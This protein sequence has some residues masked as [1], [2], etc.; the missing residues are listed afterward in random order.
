MAKDP[1]ARALDR[2][3]A[4][5]PAR[6]L[7]ERSFT[8]RGRNFHRQTG[9]LVRSVWFQT[10]RGGP[11]IFCINLTVLSP[12]LHEMVHG[13][14]L[15]SSPSLLNSVPL[16]SRRV[17]WPTEDGPN[18]WFMWLPANAEAGL[19]AE[20]E[21][22]RADPARVGQ[23]LEAD[24]PWFDRWPTVDSILERYEAGPPF[25]DGSGI[26]PTQVEHAVL[27]A[28]RG[29][30]DRALELLREGAARAGDPGAH[31]EIASRLRQSPGQDQTTRL[32]F[33]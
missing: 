19:V 15:P 2:L 17:S 20:R 18:N 14:P 5:E 1:A 8:K 11:G 10:M 28:Y 7:R 29:H 12:F 13:E 16:A 31:A 25:E 23:C 24:L 26:G 6:L 21:R 30:L 4:E 32:P 22:L 27:L 9:E 33:R 3:I